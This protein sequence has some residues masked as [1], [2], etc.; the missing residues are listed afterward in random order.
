[1]QKETRRK[2]EQAFYDY[3]KNREIATCEALND[4][5]MRVTV[6]YGKL[7]VQGGFG[8]GFTEA[9]IRA[10]DRQQAAVKWYLVVDKTMDKFRGEYKDRLVTYRYFQKK[11]VNETARM[12][13]VDRATFF[14]W[15]DEILA[16]A[17]LWAREYR[18]IR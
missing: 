11:S 18:L 5:A 13:N 16:T 1:M 2:I 6:D 10:V 17:E 12:L 8:G 15:K 14:R 7:A 3:Q 4:I 9:L